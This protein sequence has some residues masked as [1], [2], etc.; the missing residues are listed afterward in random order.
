MGEIRNAHYI[1]VGKP[2]RKR[3]LGRYWRRWEDNI[4]MDLR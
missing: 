4:G 1:S 2:E 3:L